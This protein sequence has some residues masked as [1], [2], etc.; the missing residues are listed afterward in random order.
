MHAGGVLQLDV[1]VKNRTDYDIECLSCTLIMITSE[2]DPSQPDPLSLENWKNSQLATNLLYA[3]SKVMPSL[4]TSLDVDE[5]GPPIRT[6]HKMVHHKRMV[7]T[8]T[9][10]I[11]VE[12]G[13]HSSP[14]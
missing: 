5:E 14:S 12:S 6:V 8:R 1:V 4:S 13:S 2:L 3:T 10:P 7:S 9:W 11:S